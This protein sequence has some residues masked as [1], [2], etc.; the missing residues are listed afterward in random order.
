MG[1]VGKEEKKEEDH[2]EK[3]GCDP[4]ECTIL[5]ERKI[6]WKAYLDLAFLGE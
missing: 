3:N 4:I 2:L 5:S 6:W 1:V